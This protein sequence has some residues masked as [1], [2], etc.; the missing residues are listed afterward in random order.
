MK[1]KSIQLYLDPDFKGTVSEERFQAFLRRSSLQDR[2]TATQL[3]RLEAKV[4]YL[5][6][7]ISTVWVLAY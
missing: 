3:K 7:F 2:L 5:Q 1:C 6:F 4:R